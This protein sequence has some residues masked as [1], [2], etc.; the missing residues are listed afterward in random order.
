MQCSEDRSASLLLW[1][2]S[3]KDLEAKKR[4]QASQVIFLLKFILLFLLFYSLFLN[5]KFLY[6]KNSISQK[7][8]F[9]H[10]LTIGFRYNEL[11]FS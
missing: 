5:I 2:G 8:C 9:S 1:E 6:H 4:S 11:N 10:T 3:K 7:Y